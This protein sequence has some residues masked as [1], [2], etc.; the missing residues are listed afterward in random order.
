M[1][2]HAQQLEC[3]A[4]H[5]RGVK[6]LLESIGT[7]KLA[8]NDDVKSRLIP[9]VVAVGSGLTIFGPRSFDFEILYT[10]MSDNISDSHMKPR[11]GHDRPSEVCQKDI[12]VTTS[13]RT[14]TA[15]LVQDQ[16]AAFS[17]PFV[18][19]KHG[20]NHLA[21]AQ[22]VG[23]VRPRQ[24][25]PQA[26]PKRAAGQQVWG[27]IAHHMDHEGSMKNTAMH[28]LLSCQQASPWRPESAW[29]R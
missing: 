19:A 29:P 5:E 16:E 22:T 23:R 10:N 9:E 3:K 28:V 25:L 17:I 21:S 8:G 6:T 15:Y 1:T 14:N 18:V 11:G 27:E 24:A 7:A 26:P 2:R 20:H 12:I 4:H 13:D